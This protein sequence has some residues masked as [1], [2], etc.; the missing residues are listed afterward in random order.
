MRDDYEYIKIGDTVKAMFFE[1]GI[2]A[3]RNIII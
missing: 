3:H 1:D 2:V